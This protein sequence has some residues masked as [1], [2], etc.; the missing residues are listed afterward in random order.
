MT[1][2]TGSRRSRR[3][4]LSSRHAFTLVELMLVMTILITVIAVAMPS[5]GG[6][7]RGRSLDSEARRLMALTRYGQSRAVAEGVPMVLWVD[8]TQRRY[9][10][11][12][13]S[14]YTEE[15]TK[16]VEFQLADDVQV[17]VVQSTRPPM[18]GATLPGQAHTRLQANNKALARRPHR[19]LPSI[20]FQPDGCLGETSPQAMRLTGRDGVALWLAQSR[21]H[22]H[23]ELRGQ[24]ESLQEITR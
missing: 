3:A 15:D 16:A 7:F 18:T 5:L 6:F 21:N 23:Y 13:E 2:R 24:N 1:S 17:E 11:E 22:L 19:N 14:S 20:R 4:G 12:E 8:A 10:L 9:G